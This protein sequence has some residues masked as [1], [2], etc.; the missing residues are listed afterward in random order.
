MKTRSKYTRWAERGVIFILLSVS[1][2]MILPLVGLAFDCGMLYMI[3]TKLSAAVDAAVL[4]G[5]RSL[6]RGMDLGSQ[7]GSATTTATEYFHANFPDGLLATTNIQFNIQVTETGSR[8]RQVTMAASADS[9]LYFLR[10]LR[11]EWATVAASAVA[12]RR[13][14]NLILLMDRSG[15]I[16]SAGADDEVR[17]SA[18]LFVDKFSEGRDRVGMVSFG[19]TYYVDFP[20]GFDFKTRT[21]RNLHQAIDAVVY[22]TDTYTNTPEGLWQAYERL[23]IVNEVGALN[24]IVFFTDGRPTALTANFPVKALT[25]TRYQY[26]SPY[27]STVS[28]GPSSC[29]SSVAKLGFICS[30]MGSYTSTGAT[31]GVMLRLASSTTHDEW[32]LAPNSS[33]CYYAG[34]SGTSYRRLMR[35]DIAYVPDQD[36]NGNSTW[37]YMPLT[38][39]SG[40]F[41][42]GHPY[43]GRIRPDGPRGVRYAANNAADNAA[44]RIRNDAGLRPVIY[45][46][47]L[48]GTGSEP[49]DHVFMRRVANDPDSPI[50]N[51]SQPVGLY[52]YSPTTQQLGDAFLKIASEILRLTQ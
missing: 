37:G 15:S 16:L 26:N 31:Y 19:G 30:P 36:A 4:A 5:A 18:H 52:V 17:A 14:V 2:I 46:I 47:G 8:T 13:D 23:R 45:S 11:H 28:Y 20:E 39:P 6:D 21:P 33:G 27:T 50:F 44:T 25:D 29:S 24:V 49:I 40:V 9:P 22:R 48:G 7:V 35:R 41:P 42:T 32:T 51:P 34:G 12:S 38:A 1:L 43:A 3:R 10:L